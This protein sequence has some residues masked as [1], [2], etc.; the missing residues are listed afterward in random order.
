M[1]TPEEIKQQISELE[2]Q[3]KNAKLE[4]NKSKFEDVLKIAKS[5]D[6][7]FFKI[8]N[9]IVDIDENDNEIEYKTVTYYSTLKSSEQNINSYNFHLFINCKQIEITP[10]GISFSFNVKISE[11]KLKTATEITKDEYIDVVLNNT[12]LISENMIE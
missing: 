2:T 5:Y 6:N 11:T 4:Y 1:K 7:R 3:L 8:F 9:T 12:K 10:E